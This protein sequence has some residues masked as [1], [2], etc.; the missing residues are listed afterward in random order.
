MLRGSP[1]GDSLPAAFVPLLVDLH[2]RRSFLVERV[3]GAYRFDDIN[4][5][6]DDLRIGAAVKPALIISP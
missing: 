2:R 4:R 5:S 3:I 1:F 6:V